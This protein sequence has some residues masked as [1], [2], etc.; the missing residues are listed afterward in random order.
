MRSRLTRYPLFSRRAPRCVP[1]TG[2]G[3]WVWPCARGRALDAG[4]SPRCSTPAV[5]ATHAARNTKRRGRARDWRFVVRVTAPAVSAAPTSFLD[6]LRSAMAAEEFQDAVANRDSGPI[7]DWMQS[8]IQ[9]Q[10]ISDAIASDYAERH[11]LAR[12]RLLARAFR[13]RPECPKLRCYWSFANCG[14]RKA[15]GCCSRP[16]HFYRCSLPTHP[17]RKGGLNQAA[18]SLFLFIRDVCAGDLVGWIDQRL[19]YADPGIGAPDRARLMR[20][21]LLEPLGNVYGISGKLWSMAL[22]DLLLGGDPDRERWVT[23]GASMIAVDTLVHNFLHRTGCLRRLA[24]E[25]AY[26]ARCYAPGGCAEIIE[27]LATRIDARQFHPAF[28]ATFPRFVQQA[29]WRFCAQDGLNICNGNRIDDRRRCENVLCPTYRFCE[30]VCLNVGVRAS[31]S[32]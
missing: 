14:Y 17:L 26:G 8:L 1:A 21:A 2:C 19:E 5:M 10:G 32:T 27:E 11:G 29:I 28:P 23:T 31:R 18:Y 7:F 15:S 4:Y 24:A 12:W 30:R 13:L 6:D 16:D 22:A 25:H 9:L 20:Q 3:C